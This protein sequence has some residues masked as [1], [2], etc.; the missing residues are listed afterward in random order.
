[1]SEMQTRRNRP[2]CNAEAALQGTARKGPKSAGELCFTAAGKSW[3]QV[4]PKHMLFKA[5][6]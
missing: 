3:D 6:E 2:G 1:M 4:L 5:C